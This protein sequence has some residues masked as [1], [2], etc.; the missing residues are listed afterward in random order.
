MRLIRILKYDL[1]REV[2]AWVGEEIIS[3]EPAELICSQYG[4]DYHNLSRRSYGYHVLVGLGCLFIGLSLI[5]LLGANWEFPTCMCK[6]G[7]K[8]CRLRRSC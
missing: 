2:A 5:T 8:Q 7:M 1:R 4:V 3:T 6:G